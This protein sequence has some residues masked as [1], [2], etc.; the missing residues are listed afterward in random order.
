[1]RPVAGTASLGAWRLGRGVPLSLALVAVAGVVAWRFLPL[2]AADLVAA[3]VACVALLVAWAAWRALFASYGAEA[4]PYEAACAT[5]RARPSDRP[6]ELVQIERAVSSATT[7]ASDAHLR[8]RPLLR[9]IVVPWLAEPDEPERPG[10][11][12]GGEVDAALAARHGELGGP[13]WELVRPGRER[14]TRWDAPGL[15]LAM[16]RTIVEEM[17][18]RVDDP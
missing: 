2:H 15:D 18:G 7:T 11:D 16:L 8:L 14:P 5:E 1:M 4:S 6:R 17:E 12:D 13:L 10:R 3:V 9:A